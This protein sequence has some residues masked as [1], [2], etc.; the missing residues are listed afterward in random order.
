MPDVATSERAVGQPLRAVR[1]APRRIAGA[2]SHLLLVANTNAS[3]LNGRRETVDRAASLL[4]S[5]GAFVET[6]WTGSAGEL[7][8]LVSEE[9]RRIVLIG[10]DGTL[11]AVANTAATS[12]RSHYCR[13]GGR[14]T[15]L[16]RSA[17]RSA[18]SLPPGSRS[19]ASPTRSTGSRSRPKG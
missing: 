10:G 5:F 16:G 2:G 9:E 4:R 17:C 13:A 12:P 18:S 15:W 6:R 8:E 3:G 1:R 14:T 7:D 11:H 19:R